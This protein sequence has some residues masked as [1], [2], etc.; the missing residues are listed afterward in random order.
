MGYDGKGQY[1][2]KNMDAINSLNINFD[3]EYILE[4]LVKL[5]KEIS[6]VIT[7]FNNNKYEIMSLLK[8]SKRANLR[9]SKIPAEISKKIFEQSKEWA[10]LL[11]KNLNILGHCV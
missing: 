9:H 8:I 5:K 11:Q 1:P 6:V 10:I 3:N 4:K 2:I 7:R